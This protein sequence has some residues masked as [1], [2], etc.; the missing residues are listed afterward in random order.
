MIVPLLLIIASVVLI[1][2]ASHILVKDIIEFSKKV[3]FPPYIITF[4]SLSIGSAIPEI[5][6][7][8]ILSINFLN[9][10]AFY[11]LINS[12]VLDFTIVAGIIYILSNKKIK[13]PK[14]Y[15][16]ASAFV[17][18][19]LIIFLLDNSLSQIEGFILFL[20]YIIS[21]LYI[22]FRNRQSLYKKEIYDFSIR[23]TLRHFFVIPISVAIIIANSMLIYRLVEVLL[24]SYSFSSIFIGFI[25]GF[26]SIAPELIVAIVSYVA[27][28][29][30][31][32]PLYN[33]LGT[34][35]ADVS[36]GLGIISSIHSVVDISSMSTI[37]GML[38]IYLALSHM[39]LA[40]FF[41]INSKTNKY[42][43]YFLISGYFL[44]TLLLLTFS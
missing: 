32:I 20:S 12:V 40:S 24:Y 14:E 11:N 8:V 30:M 42:L 28:R 39:I 33:I 22:V 16:I 10:V 1:V 43:G 4:L 26:F 38:F 19:L 29:S 35:V 25:L 3:D 18:I 41:F 5:S 13:I 7:S 21:S 36:L 31:D 17:F 15:V 9:D 37:L 2:I 34:F 23:S 27:L 6:N 44:Y